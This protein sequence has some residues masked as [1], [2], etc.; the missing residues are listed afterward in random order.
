[1]KP[2]IVA[3]S[4]PLRFVLSGLFL[5][6]VALALASW[7]DLTPFLRAW[8]G[9]IALLA[10]SYVAVVARARVSVSPE[11]LTVRWLRTT[12]VPTAN[13]RAMSAVSG[14]Q[15]SELSSL[16]VARLKDGT[17]VSLK[18]MLMTGSG[19]WMKA[20]AIADQLSVPFEP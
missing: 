8:E 1:M 18:P 9:A 20:K 14:S 15:F 16:P 10:L 17:A 4:S 5:F 11:S 12:T 2:E 7:Q 6:V 19:G 13:I 3:R